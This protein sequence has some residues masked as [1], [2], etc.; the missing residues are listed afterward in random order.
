[1]IKKTTLLLALAS[2]LI[3]A[4]TGAQLVE[5]H[6][7]SCHILTT[8]QAGMMSKLVAPPMGAVMF[9]LKQ[10]KQDKASATAFI[11]DYVQNPSA[12]KSV[13]ESHKVQQFGVMPSLKG[14]VSE[15]EL[16]VIAE[17]LYDHFPNE[18][19]LKMISQKQHN[20]AMNGLKK[21]PF[22]INSDALPH[23]TKILKMHW[24]KAKLGLT[25]EQKEK[26]LLIRK[27]TVSGVQQIKSK[28]VA[29]ESEIV[30][31]MVDEESL[32]KTAT[33]VDALA[34]LKAKATM[35]HLECLSK[36]MKVLTEQQIELLM[37]F[38]GVE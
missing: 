15:A 35:L 26:L 9:H 5:K 31:M 22:L 19:F 34:K 12:A 28:V 14:K 4:Q 33:K 11:V 36:T 16:K 21:S 18:A 1:M 37:P 32:E 27:E 2:G 24:D 23:L 8:P 30:E 38:W 7:T 3:Y 17:Y 13:C 6:C 29:L 20:G 10:E 25:A